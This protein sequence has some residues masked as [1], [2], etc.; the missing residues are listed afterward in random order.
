MYEEELEVLDSIPG[1]DKIAA[2][3]IITEIGDNVSQFPKANHLASWARL[4]PGNNES[5]DKKKRTRIR[6][7][8]K[9][10]FEKTF[11][12]SSFCGK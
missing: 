12:P 9:S 3:I 7:G 8:K 11:M 5:S 4:C 6:K 1:M 2:S 10:I